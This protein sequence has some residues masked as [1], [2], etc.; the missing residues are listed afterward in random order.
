MGCSPRAP[1]VVVAAMRVL[2]HFGA[3]RRPPT[4]SAEPSILEVRDA[5]GAT[6]DV[7]LSQWTGEDGLAAG[8]DRLGAHGMAPGGPVLTAYAALRLASAALVAPGQRGGRV[9]PTGQLVGELLVALMISGRNHPELVRCRDGWAVVRWRDESEREL[10]TALAGP[11]GSVP[12]DDAVAVARAA[13]L[14]VGAVR[15]PDGGAI[16]DL[17]TGALDGDTTTVRRPRVI[18]WTV[19]WAGPWAAQRLR[20]SGAGVR[21]IE[22]PRRRDGLLAWP[23]GHRWWQGLNRGKHLALLDARQP[24]DREQL[25]AAL[26]QADILLTSMTPRALRSLAVDDPWR[27]EHAPGLLHV[28]LVAF[29]APWSDAPGLGEHAAAEAGLL[30]RSG[31]APASPYPWADPLLGAA[32]LGL[33]RAWLASSRRRGGRVRLTLQQAAALPFTLAAQRS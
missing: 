7:A 23:E 10:F 24:S 22:H 11:E 25:D 14:M 27:A 16:L 5:T 1:D 8:L 9:L 31:D 29:D 19:L 17:G 33:C 21:R 18:D 28:E 2:T 12:R 15:A 6:R 13:R 4:R 20:G 32:A 3:R 26:G 30:W